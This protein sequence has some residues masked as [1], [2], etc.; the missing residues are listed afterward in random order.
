MTE[1]G[2]PGPPG[3]REALRDIADDAPAIHP[4]GGELY[5]RGR[6]ATATT[7]VLG[8]VAAVACVVLVLAVGWQVLRPVEA[9]VT[10]GAEQSGGVPEVIYGPGVGEHAGVPTAVFD[11]NLPP[12]AA[13]YLLFGGRDVVV[14]VGA[15]GRYT[16]TT[17]PG[18]DDPSP[19]S[20]SGP[21]LSPDGDRLAYGFQAKQGPVGVA[22]MDLATGSLE[23]I[24][25]G[26]ERGTLI[27]TLQ[28]SPDGRTIV[29]SG[30]PVT[31]SGK[32]SGFG[33][34]KGGVI[35]VRTGDS[36]E[37][38][39]AG[40]RWDNAGICDDGTAL[41]FVWPAYLASDGGPEQRTRQWSEVSAEHGS[42]SP[43]TA[44][45]DLEDDGSVL[46]WLHRSG[47]T[48]PVAVVQEPDWVDEG[49]GSRYFST[50]TL[51]LWDFEQSE[52]SPTS[53]V[54]V[55]D[56]NYD[57][58]FSVATGLMSLD[59]PTVPAGDDPWAGPWWTDAWPWFAL[60]AGAIMLTLLVTRRYRESRRRVTASA[61]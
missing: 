15:D 34:V 28:W 8:A 11:E 46:G 5:R 32:G 54:G 2:L 48:F 61:G 29:W 33:R 38:P 3:L 47:E 16:R 45:S 53:Q 35:D 43:P 23:R 57:V 19:V 27:R 18:L 59:E 30:Q 1:P 36:T 51:S 22:I 25:P 39:G 26:G 6:R 58:G 41:R 56:V 60:G 49:G 55:I 24:R 42:C 40:G 7:R 9:P 44:L 31:F 21:L 12:V 10:D 50:R 4:D 14:L 37:L 17:L 13:A 52:T 20:A